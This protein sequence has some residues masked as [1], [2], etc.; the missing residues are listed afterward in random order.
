M[1]LQVNFSVIQ[2]SNSLSVRFIE[3]TGVYNVLSNPNGYGGVNASLAQVSSTLVKVVRPDG[4]AIN[5]SNL[6]PL[7]SSTNQFVDITNVQLGYTSA[8][9]LPDGYYIF[10]YEVQGTTPTQNGVLSVLNK[11]VLLYND[12][13]CCV[14][15]MGA[16][17]CGCSEN[18][19]V[20]AFNLFNAMLAANL[21]GNYAGAA[22]I[23]ERLQAMCNKKCGC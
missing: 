9:K 20:E 13:E 5:L 1:A 3:T 6:S 4:T 22:E 7:P 12:V 14:R 2:A 23:L 8:T 18:E 10:T 15:K 11:Q 21:C 16:R 17:S 19:Y